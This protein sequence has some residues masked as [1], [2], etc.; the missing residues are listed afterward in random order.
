MQSGREDTFAKRMSEHFGSPFPQRT[1]PN[2]S[3]VS[4]HSLSRRTRT[5]TQC[6]RTVS[7]S[8]RFPCS[9]GTVVNIKA[10]FYSFSTSFL[11]GKNEQNLE[12][13]SSIKLQKAH[14]IAHESHSFLRS[15]LVHVKDPVPTLQRHIV[16]YHIT[17]SGCDRTYTGQTGRLLGTRL[18]E[19]RGSVRRHY[20]NLCLALH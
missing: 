9:M 3:F 18:K 4:P 20:T 2:S 7:E 14:G 10:N 13:N 17:C 15:I 8:L 16:I 5:S 19:H 1:I 11:H 6:T 12:L